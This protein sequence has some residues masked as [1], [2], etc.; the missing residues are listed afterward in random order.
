MEHKTY[1]LNDGREIHIRAFQPEDKD[2][3]NQFYG[4][5]SE[6]SLRWITPMTVDDMEHRIN[7]PDYFI[8]L[9]TVH[10]GRIVGY[11]EIAKDP[12]RT[13][14]ELNIHIHQDYQ[15]VGL[16]TAMMIM[17]VKEATDQHLHG[18]NLKVAASNMKAVHLFRKCGF[19]EILITK[20][21]YSGE[22]HDTLHMRK[23]LNR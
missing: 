1:T 9:V 22:K 6:E 19:Q 8:G 18:V 13:D 11:G 5:L 16:G 4:S 3:L 20:E 23:V 2:Q 12:Q 17:L 15:G 7:F 21:L 10:N 14:G